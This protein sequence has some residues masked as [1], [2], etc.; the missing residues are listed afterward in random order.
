MDWDISDI[1]VRLSKPTFMPMQWPYHETSKIEL[2][3][4]ENQSAYDAVV[5]TQVDFARVF[6]DLFGQKIDLST[7]K[8]VLELVAEAKGKP[9]PKDAEGIAIVPADEG[10]VLESDWNQIYSIVEGLHN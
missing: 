8:N 2:Q 1:S 4:N 6:G 3:K 5:D 9:W 7:A 10:V